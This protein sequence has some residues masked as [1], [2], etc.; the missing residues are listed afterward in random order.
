LNSNIANGLS[1]GSYTITVD[2]GQCV[3]TIDIDV[4]SI[5]GPTAGF[6]LNP[7]TVNL[8]DPTVNIIDNSFGA[9][10]WYYDLDDGNTS[11]LPSFTY[12][13]THE[14]EYLIMQIVSDNFGCL[15]TAYQTLVVNES[16]AIYIPN[17]FSPN[18]DGR[19]DYFHPYGIGIDAD[20]WN[21]RI[22]DRWGH[23]VFVT[24]DYN[25]AWNGNYNGDV[26]ECSQ[27]VYSYHIT[28]KTTTGKDKEF[29]GRVT[30]LP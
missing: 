10:N 26:N 7:S 2:D 12:S 15:D 13:Y 4:S 1:S 29:F 5:N 11:I 19:N 3:R 20:T 18:G 16:F 28:F 30:K 25:K 17:A 21:M 23:T 8:D 14:G 9:T 27:G 24:T 22:Y 6:M